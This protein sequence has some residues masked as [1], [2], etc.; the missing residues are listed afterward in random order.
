M[1]SILK[2]LRKVEEEGREAPA[3]ALGGDF[4]GEADAAPAREQGASHARRQPWP[5]VAA[6]CAVLA[7][8]SAGAWWLLRTPAPAAADAEVLAAQPIAQPAPVFQR[9]PLPAPAAAAPLPPAPA[10]AATPSRERD[11]LA[12][13]L[14]ESGEA[15]ALPSAPQPAPM[16]PVSHAASAP[17]TLAAAAPPPRPT[18]PPAPQQPAVRPQPTPAPELAAQPTPAPKP[19]VEPKAAAPKPSPRPEPKRVAS[20]PPAPT[21]YVDRTVWHP[22]VERRTA[23]VRI[24]GADAVELKQGDVRGDLTLTRIEPSAVIF[25]HR[26]ESIRVR[27]GSR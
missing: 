6:A 3:P 27:V 4:L 18:P 8:A 2:A 5:L 1:S 23:R 25:D 10:G 24:G 15:P 11:V 7:L 17:T 9:H 16:P 20:L 22:V 12:Q 14:A 26:G 13:Q 19:R 21:V